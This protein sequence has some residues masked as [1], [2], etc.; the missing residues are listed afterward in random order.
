MATLMQAVERQRER[1]MTISSESI[2]IRNL[3]QR[4]QPSPLGSMRALIAKMLE[5]TT[6][7]LPWAVI[8][9]RFK[10][11][12]PDAAVEGP[13]ER[14]YREA[15]TPGSGGLVEY[16]RDVSLGVIDITGSKVFGWVEVEIPRDKAGGSPTSVPPGPGRSGLIDYAVNA[17][18]R[19]EGDDALK[20]FLGP[21]AVYTQNWS[22]ED[23]PASADWSTP[24]W[25]PF[26]IDGSADGSGRVGLTPPHNGNIT[27]HE[28]GHVFGMDHDVGPDLMTSSDYSDPCC[29]MSQNGPFIH[30]MWRVAF[31]P[32][33][34]LPHLMQRDWMYKRRVYYDDGGWLSQ[35]DGIT[36]PLAPISRPSVR[37]NLG[38][39]LAYTQ[40]ATSWD[41][42]LECVI[43]TEWNRGVAGAPLF[44]IRR[45][46]SISGAGDRPA[47]LGFIKP[48]ATVGTTAE[49]V[50]PSGNVR[51]Q[52]E[53][54]DLPGPIFKVSAKKL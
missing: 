29:I 22:K 50:E 9:C 41:Y 25:F 40:D 15:F 26:W 37:A 7:N 20:G 13:V 51:F 23:A 17:L 8:L 30:P 18:K 49:F 27:A 45:I 35:P 1:G 52:V 12:T 42:Y 46:V 54:T 16:W 19:R 14:F 44:F 4:F 32:A 24:E 11:S 39:R 47:Y 21:I 2:S 53:L 43:P 3:Q 33:V 38:I 5:G 28:M 34:C 36:L 31:G 10:G 48:P 6:K